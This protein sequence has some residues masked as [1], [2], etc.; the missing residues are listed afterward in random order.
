LRPASIK[1][2]SAAVALVSVLLAICF[3][4]LVVRLAYDA[5]WTAL[6]CAGDKFQRPP[7][8]AQHEYVFHDSGGYD[9][10]F[11]QL[12][13]HDPLLAKHYD[14]FIDAPRLRYRRILM[15]GL[16]W[17]LAGGN[18]ACVDGALFA[19]C[20]GFLA[21]GTF[22]LAR[23]A[24]DEGRSPL[25]GLLF[26]IAPATFAALE[27][28]TV[29]ISL[30]ALVPAALLAARRQRWL[31]LWLVAAAAML[32]KETGVLVV[33]AIV[34]WLMRESRYRLAAI[35]A[36]SILPA[37]A[38]YAFVQSRTH[39]DYSMADFTPVALFSS[40][41]E[42]LPPGIVNLIYRIASVAAAFAL[43]WIAVR[44]VVMAIGNHFRD[45]GWLLCFFL[46]AL[47]LIFQNSGI[48]AEPT[49]YTRIYSPLLVA[50]IVATWRRGFTQSLIAFAI[51]AL[52]L[53]MQVGVHV[54][55]PLI[56]PWLH[57]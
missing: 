19:V 57:Q 30:T 12:I 33:G 13:A 2:S 48:W 45:L 49:G 34:I 47:L 18:G 1:S 40:I 51:V 9:G 22:C 44:C 31:L 27:R 55:G 7:E 6:F 8:I 21:L 38:W 39:G 37:V 42:P 3:Q 4:W 29:D 28:M 56:R 24:E 53:A 25:W 32:S 20:W 41:G 52:P 43:A 14:R 26:L 50:L 23:L 54:T 11:Y 10:Q 36:T 17:L 46:S 35:M 16:G 15:S 5:N